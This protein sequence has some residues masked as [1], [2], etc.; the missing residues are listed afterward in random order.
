MTHLL[1][2]G[3]DSG[4]I[5]A[6]DACGREVAGD[7]GDVQVHGEDVWIEELEVEVIV[8]LDERLCL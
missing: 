8:E 5:V 6:N 3:P 1:V 4:R 2:E 7:V